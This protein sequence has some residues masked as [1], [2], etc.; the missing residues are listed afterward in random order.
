MQILSFICIIVAAMGVFMATATSYMQ[1]L[2]ALFILSVSLVLQL[3]FDPYENWTL[4]AMEA[5]ALL[6]STV[7]LYVGLW[8]FEKDSA[9]SDNISLVATVVIFFINIVY[10]VV[11]VRIMAPA[12]VLRVKKKLGLVPKGINAPAEIELTVPVS[13]VVDVV[14]SPPTTKPTRTKKTKRA[15]KKQTKKKSEDESDGRGRTST[16]VT[17][18]AH[19]YL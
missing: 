7:T 2:A 8:T 14:A 3:S 17:N 19:G 13:V 9:S 10:L 11:V 4:N 12:A 15:M 16:T 1:G 6:V 18:P 5:S